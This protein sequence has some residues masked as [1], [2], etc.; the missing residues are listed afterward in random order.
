MDLLIE[1]RVKNRLIVHIP[2][3][4]ADHTDLARRI[5]WMADQED[6]AV[7]F[8]VFVDDS[9]EELQ[10]M[11]RVATLK[12]VT[13]ASRLEVESKLIATGDCYDTVQGIAGPDD[14]VAVLDDQGAAG[15][16][17]KMIPVNEFLA[18]R[19]DFR[20]SPA[21]SR[22]IA[23]WVSQVLVFAGFLLIIAVFAWME[24]NLHL[25]FSGGLHKAFLF[26]LFGAEL[27]VI[28]GWNKVTSR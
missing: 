25:A 26:I 9:G 6:L 28:A 5:H 20:I 7:F 21:P 23:P 3:T 1:T 12:A 13:S 2:E 22:R 8:L 18:S 14:L 11:R 27:A 4:L 15:G 10:T 17:F 19:A 16:Y 24:I